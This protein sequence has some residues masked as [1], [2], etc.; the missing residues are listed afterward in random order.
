MV[1]LSWGAILTTGDGRSATV[2]E[3]CEQTGVT[4]QALRHR[5]KAGKDLDQALQPMVGRPEAK[6]MTGQM[7]DRLRVL[8]R[9]PRPGSDAAYWTCL[10]DPELGGCG[11][12][13]DIRGSSLR[14][15]QVRSCGCLRMERFSQP[16]G[17]GK[18]S[19]SALSLRAEGMVRFH[20]WV[21]EDDRDELRRISTELRRRR[22]S[23]ANK[24]PR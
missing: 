22:R 5:L 17:D 10:C 6:D 9:S 13:K 16:D 19:R 2:R 3:W 20:T 23:A 11:T 4:R 1:D 18:P 12:I 24:T 15:G 14:S 8:H 21:H 7:H